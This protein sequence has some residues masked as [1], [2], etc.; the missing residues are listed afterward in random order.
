[1]QRNLKESYY[2][3]TRNHS[4]YI[5]SLLSQ[6]LNSFK[7]G[8][9]IFLIE[10]LINKLDLNYRLFIRHIHEYL[11]TY[12]SCNLTYT[13]S[14]LT[15]TSSNL[16]YTSSN[17]T[18]TSSNLTYTSSNLT[19]TSSNLTYTSSNLTYTSSNLTY[20]SSNLTYTSSNLH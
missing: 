1:M 2:R 8:C 17:L 6:R 14:N 7:S 3:M 13:S 4:V 16:T 9:R 19:Y 12:T 20:T 11:Q 15:Y 10:V 5:L 18:Y